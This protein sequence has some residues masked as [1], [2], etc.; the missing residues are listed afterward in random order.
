MARMGGADA[1]LVTGCARMSTKISG[2]VIAYN[3]EN[4]IETCLRGARFVDQLVVVDKSSTDATAAI[5]GRIADT[6]ISVPW[7]PTVEE[8]R[9]LALSHCAHDW[10]LFL[11]DDE[12]LSP[13]AVRFLHGRHFD[14]TRDVHYL[15]LKHY[16]L[17]RFDPRAYYWPEHHARFFRRGTV[18]FRPTVHGG[19]AI[20]TDNIARIPEESGICIHHLS[21]P[22]VAGWIE[23]TN[24]YTSRPDRV[25]PETDVAGL[26]AFAH[27]RIEH[28]MAR[29]KPSGAEEY[30]AAV[31]VLRAV[32]D[33]VDRLKTYE[34]GAGD[35]GADR[36]AATCAELQSAYDAL[37]TRFAIPTGHDPAR[38]APIASPVPAPETPPPIWTPPRRGLADRLRESVRILRGG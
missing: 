4:L 19:V 18:A 12:M 9:A 3:R 33:I 10:V 2:F 36:F 24:R 21:H 26:A 30:P 31:A 35:G 17:G 16:I 11:D 5:A 22:D 1:A 34:E 29:T 27:A 8:T 23:K 37:E 32:Y 20:L 13:E 25:R 6:V 14:R 38:A 28:W 15:P 7:S